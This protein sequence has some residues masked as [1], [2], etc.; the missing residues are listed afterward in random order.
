MSQQ[1]HKKE[2]EKCQNNCS[3]CRQYQDKAFEL[4]V[5]EE[6][7]Q[8]RL[9]HLWQKYHGWIFGG[10][11]LILFLTAGIQ[12]YSSWWQKVR[13]SESDAYEKA[14][15]LANS[16]KYEQAQKAFESLISSGYTGYKKLAQMQLADLYMQQN[17]VPEALGVL[18]KVV[19]SCKREDSLCLTALISYTGYQIEDGNPDQMLALLRPA[20]ENPFF[21]GLATEI[22]V[23]YL[24]RQGKS[25]EAKSLVEKALKNPNLTLQMRSRLNSFVLSGGK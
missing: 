23:V 10:V 20:L 25:L 2:C 24:N 18:K 21:Q 14:V 12:L 22:A 15:I 9:A 7:E 13:L 19:D 11:C 17:K 3:S 4:E 6:M 16:Q 1:K 8:E 5:D